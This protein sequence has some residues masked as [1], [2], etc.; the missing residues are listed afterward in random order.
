MEATDQEKPI[1]MLSPFVIQKAMKGICD[2]VNVT[3]LRS[4][5]LLVEVSR[6]AQATSLLKQTTFAT[7]SIKIT[8]H[9][10]MNSCKGVIR[11]RDLADMDPIKLVEELRCIGVT[12]ARNIFQ[13]RNG[14]KIKAAAIILTFSKAILP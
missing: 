9:R 13:T 5:A 1:S 3:K 7:I 10:T 6:P 14:T 4:D 11:D 2:V 12:D 8:P